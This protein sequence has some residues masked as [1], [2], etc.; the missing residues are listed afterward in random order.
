M[1]VGPC[2]VSKEAAQLRRENKLALIVGFSV[3]LVV[4]VL[5]SDHLSTARQQDVADGLD[6]LLQVP[7]GRAFVEAPLRTEPRGA[8]RGVESSPNNYA[9]ITEED[10]ARSG[11]DSR[12]GSGIESMA[13]A[14]WQPG[15][16]RRDSDGTDLAGAESS[17]PI[18]FRYGPS[19]IETDDDDRDEGMTRITGIDPE[20]IRKWLGGKEQAALVQPGGGIDQSET[21]NRTNGR[22][23]ENPSSGSTGRSIAGHI[24]RD[25]KYV[26][27]P[28]DTLFEICERLYGD[29]TKWRE[30]VAINKGKIRDDGTVFVGVTIDLAP[31]AKPTAV[32]AAPPR[33]G[34]TTTTPATSS[35]RTYTIKKGDTLSEIVQR[36]VGSIRHLPRVRELNPWLA[37]QNDNIRVG[38][39]LTLPDAR[40][41]SARAH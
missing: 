10:R 7:G 8:S 15:P 26:I 17:G 13:D 27:Q 29:G 12:S 18:E 35:T 24:P 40:H 2:V 6:S 16:V 22:R 32:T 30:L 23:I 5:V 11:T 20:A 25:G 41:A 37:K 34:S 19:V 1:P 4:A 39:K 3:L 9:A 21:S 38:Q 14:D 36:E 31:G 28:N 33:R